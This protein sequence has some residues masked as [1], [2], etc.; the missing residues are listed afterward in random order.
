[1]VFRSPYANLVLVIQ[2]A[3]A[4]PPARPGK[5][6]RF[7]DGLYKT[8]AKDEITFIRKH[9]GF[10]AYIFAEEEPEAETKEGK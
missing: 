7:H 3:S 9:P 4:G 10:G 1:M 6:I 8:D 5:R 2:T